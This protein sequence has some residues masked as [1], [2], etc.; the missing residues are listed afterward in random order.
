VASTAGRDLDAIES[1]L[2]TIRRRAIPKA[3]TAKDDGERARS[4]VQPLLDALEQA[5]ALGV[6]ATVGALARLLGLDQS[7]ASKI[8]S[9][10]IEFG[11]VRR[12]ADQS[13]GRRS[14]LRLT[15]AGEK[16]LAQAHK[17]RQAVFETAMADWSQRQRAE[18]ARLLTKFVAD[19]DASR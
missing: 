8:A 12:A 11:L 1:A 14:L 13:D 7:R 18:F 15:R 19:L 17:M 6:P 5:D 4:G 16:Q 2:I 10:A 9:V 3:A